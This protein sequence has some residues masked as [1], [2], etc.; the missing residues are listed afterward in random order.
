MYNTTLITQ[1]N[2]R[3]F[4]TIASRVSVSHGRQNCRCRNPGTKERSSVDGKFSRDHHRTANVVTTA[5]LLLP[6]KQPRR[7]CRWNGRDTAGRSPSVPPAQGVAS[8][9]FRTTKRLSHEIKRRTNR[10]RNSSRTN[11]FATF[12]RTSHKKKTCTHTDNFA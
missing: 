8:H 11:V 2:K 9:H 12:I 1:R 5:E 10:Q 7:Y 4:S 6:S 3:N